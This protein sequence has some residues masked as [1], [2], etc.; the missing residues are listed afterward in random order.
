MD[1]WN[2]IF[3]I[4][5]LSQ[6]IIGIQGNMSFIFYYLLLYY[7]KHILKPTDLILLHIMAANALII[8]SFGVPHTMS[9]FGLK[10]FFKD[11]TCI[12]LIYIQGISRS[13]SIGTTC[14]LS[15]YQVMKI[16]PRESCWEDYKHRA[17]KY[18]GSSI[19]ILWVFF[20]LINFISI[21]H[22]FISMNSKNVTRK[23]DY[24]YCTIFV[25][26][27]ISDL[28]Y[29]V[30]VVC[31]E[32]FLSVLFAWSSMSMIIILY[33]H[34]QRVQHIRSTHG[35]NRTSPDSR[36]TQ[37]ILLL[38]STFLVFYTLSSILRGCIVLFHNHSWWLA[39]INPAI[40]LCFPS[41]GHFVL[42]SPFSILSKLRDL[43]Q[44]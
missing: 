31:P 43:D 36:A 29:A 37:N 19:S 41:F 11:F 25:R 35:S 32:V 26:N 21:M 27:E 44:K 6:T 9:A 40:S 14:V 5:F 13:V 28:L 22:S 8:L 15:V 42:M 24:G 4:I 30:L 33:R 10:Q 2:L 39:N 17:A 1:F 16:S 38:V 34:K 18:I 20:M 7:R 3:Q 23:R 12:F